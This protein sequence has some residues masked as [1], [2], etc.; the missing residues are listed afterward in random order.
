MPRVFWMGSERISLTLWENFICP[1]WDWLTPG[2]WDVALSL[3]MNKSHNEMALSHRKFLKGSGFTS[4]VEFTLLY[5]HK[6]GRKLV[7]A[8][9]KKK[10]TNHPRFS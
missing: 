5:H 10:K 3:G 6:K 9:R 4:Q 8:A 1:F 2:M 7:F